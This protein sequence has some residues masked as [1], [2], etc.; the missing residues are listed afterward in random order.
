MSASTGMHELEDRG[1]ETCGGHL[2]TTCDPKCDDETA[3]C[4]EMVA[5]RIIGSIMAMEIHEW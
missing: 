4:H 3:R 2:P 1:K 5:L